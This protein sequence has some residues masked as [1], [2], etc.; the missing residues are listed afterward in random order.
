[1]NTHTLL[2]ELLARTRAMGQ[3][4]VEELKL[5]LS[6]LRAELTR[7]LTQW[8]LHPY[9]LR[10]LNRYPLRRIQMNES[11]KEKLMQEIKE[12]LD[13]WIEGHNV[14]INDDTIEDLIENIWESIDEM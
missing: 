14:K 3:G 5:P 1:M 13:C 7:K 12:K 2:N 4:E 11:E 8:A 10:D 6:L 9:N